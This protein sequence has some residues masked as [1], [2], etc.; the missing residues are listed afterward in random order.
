MRDILGTIASRYLIAILNLVLIFIN[1]KALGVE[2]VGLIGL[3]IASINIAMMF[4]GILSGNTIV[5]FMNRYS[6][7]AVFAPSY[8]WT[9]VGSLIACSVMKIVGMLPEGYFLHIYLLSILMS[10]VMANS[11]FLLGKDHIKGFNIT[12]MLQGGMLF[13]VL[14]YLYYGERRQEVSSYIAGMYIANGIAFII[15]LLMLFPYF[16]HPTEET[17]KNYTL[18]SLLR[19][20]FAYG[21]WGSADNIAE[22]LTTRLNYFLIGRFGG[23]SSVG[24]LDAGT[25]MSES[26]W[27]INRSVGFIEYGHVAKSNDSQQHKTITLQYLKLTFCA[28]TLATAC[29][30]LIPEWIYTDYLFSEQFQGIR[31]V[32][33]GLSVGIIAFGCNGI[34]SQYFIGSGKIR[35]SA[36]CSFIGLATLLIAGVILI[37]LYGV[38]GSAICSSIAFCCMLC[39]SLIM[40]CKITHTTV[41]ELLINKKDWEFIR[42]AFRRRH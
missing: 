1:A 24:L 37:P 12:Y 34:I 39:F 21:L 35:Y 17:S 38:V 26:V 36:V 5:Y 20:M 9:V 41:S 4:N 7:K 42:T 14:L 13:I 16:K 8:V 6:M 33:A 3:I 2:G 25:K 23:L 40:F 30:L 22:A 29:I 15:S 19:E 31:K 32:I 11:R 18:S 27:H 10:L 28:V